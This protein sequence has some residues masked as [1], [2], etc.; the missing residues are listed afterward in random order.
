MSNKTVQIDYD[1]Y[2]QIELVIKEQ[3]ELIELL[4]KQKNVV[5]IDNR[6]GLHGRIEN[7]F[8]H[9]PKIFVGEEIAKNYLQKEYDYLDK[10]L[11]SLIHERDLL[12]SKVEELEG[13]KS[14][15]NKFGVILYQNIW[16]K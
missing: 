10:K 13:L 12:K 6:V 3:Q 2:T 4:K 8:Y 7:F 1:E 5:L 14:K 9:I 15:L 16:K 11:I